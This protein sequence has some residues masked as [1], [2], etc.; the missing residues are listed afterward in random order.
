MDWI[1]SR[2]RITRLKNLWN[3][4][5]FGK[6]ELKVKSLKRHKSSKMRQW[7]WEG[8]FAIIQGHRFIWWSSERHFDD[9][10]DPLGQIF[11]AGHAGLAGK[12]LC[13]YNLSFISSL[14]M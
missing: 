12:Y 13:V 7:D 6:L 11:F 8:M 5:W 14:S 9:G 3:A 10:V 4:A 1:A 2:K